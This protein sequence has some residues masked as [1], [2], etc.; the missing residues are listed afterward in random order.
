MPT[1]QVIMSGVL[2]GLG[3]A[4]TPASAFALA[5]P[6]A[7]PQLNIAVDDGRTSATEGDQPTY[8]T[9]V[10]NLGTD[11]VDEVQISQS[12]PAGLSLISADHD[13]VASGGQV[14]WTV[15]LKPGEDITLTTV[16]RVG[17]TPGELLRMA[18]VACAT[19]KDGSKPLVCATDSDLLPAGAAAN[20]PVATTSGPGYAIGLAAALAAVV[21]AVGGAI[22]VL[23]RTRRRRRRS[24]AGK[25]AAA[26]AKATALARD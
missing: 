8:A 10:R 24:A 23:R 16:G 2:I 11:D 19:A 3:L 22:T 6:A 1:P 26:D 12:I 4:S 9:K 21:A 18:V 7:D 5:E 13:G 17:A 20:A 14:T 15:N 25:P